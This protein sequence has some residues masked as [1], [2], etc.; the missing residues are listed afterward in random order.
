VRR[1]RALF[2]AAMVAIVVAA[3]G[4]P[5][6]AYHL[7]GPKWQNTPNSG[8]CATINVQYSSA[9][10]TGDKAAFDGARSAWNNSAANVVLPS[11]GGSLTV[12]DTSDNNVSWDGY[13]SYT[14]HT[15]GGVKYFT[16][17]HV[18]LNYYYTSGYSAATKQGV[19]AHELGHAIGLDHTSG[20]VL[21][22]PNTSSRCGLT[23]PVGDDVNGTNHLY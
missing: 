1:F 2:V 22:N 6:L 11:A 21:M 10:Y 18:L 20:C 19:A 5:A 17:A 23:G 12:D 14:W 8:C 7:E 16:N 3:A 9:F 4:T 13:T 15:T